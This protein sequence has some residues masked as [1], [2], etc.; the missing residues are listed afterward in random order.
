MAYAKDVF[1][2]TCLLDTTC[3][4]KVMAD[5]TLRETDMAICYTN[6]VLEAYASLIAQVRNTMHVIDFNERLLTKAIMEMD[7]EKSH[8]SNANM[9]MRLSYGSIKD[10]T[11]GGTHYNYFTNSQS[12]LD[13]IAQQNEIADYVMEP[14]ITKLLKKG[15]FGKYK[16]KK[17]KQMQLCF[18]SNNDITGGNSGSPM[19]D[20]N[21]HV[22]GLAFDGNWEAMAGDISFDPALQRCIGVDIR[23]VLWII[24]QWGGGK[25]IIK[26]LG[27]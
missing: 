13:K 22:I 25:N 15:K 11:A 3:V 17:T 6:D 7:S 18:L 23:F 24:D 8:Y 21:G 27:L 12:L 9:T 5:S 4:A 19:F 20:A 14:E 16:D 1:A 26:E 10:Y 2:K